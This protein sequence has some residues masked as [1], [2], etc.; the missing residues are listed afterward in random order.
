MTAPIVETIWFVNG[1]QRHIVM[2]APFPVIAPSSV[3]NL[4][5]YYQCEILSG[6]FTAYMIFKIWNISLK[7]PII[8]SSVSTKQVLDY[9]IPENLYWTTDMNFRKISLTLGHDYW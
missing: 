1:F 6:V 3:Q 4:T 9:L 2:A 7:W 8:L 5:N